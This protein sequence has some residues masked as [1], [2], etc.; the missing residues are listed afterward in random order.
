MKIYFN[1]KHFTAKCILFFSAAMQLFTYE[2]MMAGEK[3]LRIVCTEH[4]EII[5][6]ERSRKSAEI[7]FD[8]AEKVYKEVEV[9]DPVKKHYKKMYF[10]NNRFVGGILIG[11]ISESGLFTDAFQD[12]YTMERML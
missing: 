11:D 3:D 9:T 1:L 4:F 5:F 2:G 8:G 10:V 6:P 7:I 12:Q